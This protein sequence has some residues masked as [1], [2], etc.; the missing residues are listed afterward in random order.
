[1]VASVFT[2]NYSGNIR[3]DSWGSV[4]TDEFKET[5]FPAVLSLLLVEELQIVIVKDLE[6]FIPGN[7]LKVIL[8]ISGKVDPEQSTALP[9]V[10]STLYH[11]GFSISGLCPLLNFFMVF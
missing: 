6:E 9:V 3:T 10:G 7:I 11:R 5:A 2:R 8:S 4:V 1:M